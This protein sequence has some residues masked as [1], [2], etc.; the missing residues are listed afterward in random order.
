M[1]GEQNGRENFIFD[2]TRNTHNV[3]NTY[4]R[5][6][7]TSV[8]ASGTTTHMDFLSNGFKI[9]GTFGGDVNG[10]GENALYMAWGDVP[11]KYNNT[12]QQ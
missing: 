4:L 12:H 3:V 6:G 8:E 11:F 1:I 9:R 7:R 5:W 10:D 2:S